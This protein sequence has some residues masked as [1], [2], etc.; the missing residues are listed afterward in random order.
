MNVINKTRRPLRVPL[1]GGKTLF[2]APGGTGQ[3]TLK[4]KEHP[5]LMALVEAGDVEFDEES[6]SKRAAGGHRGAG[7]IRSEGHETGGGIRKSGDR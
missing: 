7:T 4:A 5:P 3:A 6:R 1:P 2:L